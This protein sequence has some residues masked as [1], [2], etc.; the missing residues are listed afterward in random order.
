[1]TQN[2]TQQHEKNTI[3][4]LHSDAWNH[5]QDCAIH[6]HSYRAWVNVFH[7]TDPYDTT[8]YVSQCLTGWINNA[9]TPSVRKNIYRKVLDRLNSS[10][11]E[12]I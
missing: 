2:T 8:A 1:M 12:E 6:T 4:K 11:T 7:I 10:Q 3:D 5:M 9:K